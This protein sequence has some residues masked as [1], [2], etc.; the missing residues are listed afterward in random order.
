MRVGLVCPFDVGSPGGVQQVTGD[1]V[2]H[3]RL[4]GDEVVY[5]VAGKYAYQGGPGYDEGILPAGRPTRI[6]AN[7]SMVPLT[8]APTA[9]WRV[10][11]ALW[12]VDVI[13][14]HEPFIPLVGWAALTVARPTIVTFHADAPGWVETLYRWTPLIDRRMRQ[15]IL[16]AVSESAARSIPDEWGEVH[17]VPNA[18]DVST[19]DLPVGRIDRRIAFLGRDDPRK[20]LDVLLDAWPSI[21]TRVPQAELVVM[22]AERGVELQGVEFVGRVS[23]GEKKRLLATSGIFVAPNTGGES[24]GMVVLEGM[25]A[26]CAVVASDLEAFAVVLADSGLT[27]PVGDSDALADEVVRLLLDPGRARRLGDRARVR[28]GKFD[29][30]QIVPEYRALYE[31]AL[32]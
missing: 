8:L 13:H 25:A 24:F 14:V 17:L 3:L 21:R 9:W 27:F 32:S 16:T 22:G 12:D 10:R 7:R 2:D 18:L 28:S 4:L 30:S 5:V 23:G 19:Y 11:H 1:L 15:T 31:A 6:R 20:G 29:W 26:G